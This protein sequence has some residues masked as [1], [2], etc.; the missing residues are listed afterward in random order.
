M[1]KRKEKVVDEEQL[2]QERRDHRGSTRKGRRDL[3]T[4]NYKEDP[5]RFRAHR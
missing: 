1:T 4:Y 3:P 2:V 5:S